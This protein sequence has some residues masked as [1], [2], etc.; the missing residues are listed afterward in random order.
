MECAGSDHGDTALEAHRCLTRGSQEFV[1]ERR[2]DQVVPEHFDSVPERLAFGRHQIA[3][4][5]DAGGAVLQRG[6]WRVGPRLRTLIAA[7][8][9]NARRVDAHPVEAAVAPNGHALLRRADDVGEASAVQHL[10]VLEHLLHVA[11]TAELAGDDVLRL[12]RQHRHGAR[13]CSRGQAVVREALQR[14]ELLP[15]LGIQFAG[16][17]DACHAVEHPRL[18]VQVDLGQLGHPVG[19]LDELGID[20]ALVAFLEQRVDDAQAE[21]GEGRPIELD[22][23]QPMA[24]IAESLPETML[25]HHID[26]PDEDFTYVVHGCSS[27]ATQTRCQVGGCRRYR[28]S[29]T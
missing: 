29:A 9:S 23:R 28:Q 26:A 11:P 14:I 4:G 8:Q 2:R 13:Q 10:H 20:E 5:D 12:A 3:D 27:F 1:G 7:R 25:A 15:V 6:Q 19:D 21:L 16:R 18:V 17:D 24:A 22:L